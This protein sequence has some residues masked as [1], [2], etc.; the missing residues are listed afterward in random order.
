MVFCTEIYAFR[1]R[2]RFLRSTTHLPHL[3]YEKLSDKTRRNCIPLVFFGLTPY[4]RTVSIGIWRANYVSAGCGEDHK[5]DPDKP[6][7]M[8]IGAAK[9]ETEFSGSG[10]SHQ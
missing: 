9:W 8:P 3:R 1:T 6:W 4:R 5:G 10:L 2:T 7:L